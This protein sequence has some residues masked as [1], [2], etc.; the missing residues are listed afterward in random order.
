MNNLQDLNKQELIKKIN[1]L[2]KKL[3][4]LQNNKFKDYIDN[5]IDVWYEENKDDVDLGNTKCCGFWKVDLIPDELEKH[6]YKK[7][8]KIMYSLLMDLKQ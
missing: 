7:I 3:S 2:E 1:N 4:I 8:F 5:Y 6:M